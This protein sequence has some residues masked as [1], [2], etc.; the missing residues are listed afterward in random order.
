MPDKTLNFDF[1]AT[2][3]GSVPFQDIEDTC[4][5]IL[6]HLPVMPFWPQFVKRSHLEDMIIQFSEGLPLLRII[7]EKRSLVISETG[8][9]ESELVDFY[10]HFLAQDTDHFAVGRDYAPG[11]YTL[12][13]IIDQGEIQSPCIKGQ[14]VGPV[15]FAAA[16]TDVNGNSVLH[17][18]ELL[19]AMTQGLA[20]KA[21]WQVKIYLDSS[22]LPFSF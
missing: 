22:A 15:T 16:I 17:N 8:N 2:C 9:T 14:T 20:I 5:D 19:E 3:I 11:L 10:E 1:A 18:P 6:N 7:E 13:E 4:R 21:L 12:L